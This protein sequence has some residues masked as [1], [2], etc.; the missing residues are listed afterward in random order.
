M[1]T[2]KSKV[3]PPSVDRHSAC[4]SDLNP[5]TPSPRSLRHLSPNH[6]NI[7][8]TQPTTIYISM[9]T[10]RL[11]LPPE[12]ILKIIQWLPFEGGEGIA[13][14]KAF[15]HLKQLI[16]TYEHSITHWFMSRELRHAQ[17]DF[18]Y[19]QKLNLK[20]LAECVSSYDMV[21]AIMLEL[22]WRENCVAVEAHNSAA[23]N[24]GLL[25]LH[26]L[27]RIG[28]SARPPSRTQSTV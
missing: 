22:T 15:P 6:E 21:D 27:A 18:P 4:C 3:A 2:T 9:A 28:K 16:E 14:L 12:I 23:V 17:V 20:W 5:T 25:L 13:G 8:L 1:E 11:S 7:L 19:C 10:P 24:A 26:Q